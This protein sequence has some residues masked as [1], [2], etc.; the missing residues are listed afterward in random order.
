MEGRPFSPRLAKPLLP[1]KATEASFPDRTATLELLDSLAGLHPHFTHI[2]AHP[3]ILF[4]LTF[5]LEL[6]SVPV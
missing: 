1:Q 4:I 6:V 3:H 2:L 5:D